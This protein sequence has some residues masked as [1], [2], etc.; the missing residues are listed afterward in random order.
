[1]AGG[2]ANPHK[3]ILG[4]TAGVC[5]A[6]LACDW[7]RSLKIWE[8]ILYLFLTIMAKHNIIYEHISFSTV[9]E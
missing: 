5:H 1:M 3:N 8:E 4:I 9:H 6:C 7:L 2:A